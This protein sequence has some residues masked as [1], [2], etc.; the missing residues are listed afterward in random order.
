MPKLLQIN[1]T[2]NWGST[3]RIAEQIGS[4]AKARGWESYIAYGR[5]GN[6]S[7]SSLI[8][9]GNSLDIYAHVLKARLFD[10]AG[11][12][13]CR[14]TQKLIRQIKKIKPDVVQLHNI[15]G[16]YLNYKLLFEYLNK[17]DIKVVWIFHDCWA[18][19]GHC[20]H[21]VKAKCA[22]WQEQC[23][24]C[25]LLSEYPR[26]CM[27]DRSMYNYNLK[28]TLLGH[29]RNLTV[30]S[31]SEWM[32]GLVSSSFLNDKDRVVIHNGV[33][34]NTFR[35]KLCAD[36]VPFK[37]LA[38]S[39]VWNKDK[40]LNDLY[41]LRKLLPSEFE[42]GVVGLSEQQLSHLPSGI[43]GVI[44]TQS[45]D[46]L[47]ELYSSADVLVNPTYADTFP[48][49]NLEALACGTP[50]I[51]YR[52]GGS[53]EAVD[54][55]TGIVVE[56]GDVRGL[57]EAVMKLKAHPLSREACRD[58]AEKYFDKDKCFEKYIDLYEE[59]IRK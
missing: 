12:G 35:P 26:S 28:K 47:V 25:P 46:E 24:D 42:I 14:A 44:R 6:D 20:A 13:S 11:L 56:Q 8:R 23:S 58:R 16:Y 53:P 33:D 2:A 48:T 18:F 31:V 1:A 32:N 45:L 40:G 37:L 41:E 3:G 29:S 30:V 4:A 22:K 39:N 50:V 52:T 59:L 9:F 51:T 54:D 27:L 57:A 49:V 17:T 19:T 34:L 15:H 38:V 5:T 43:N 55:K 21:F 10:A 36:D 7:V